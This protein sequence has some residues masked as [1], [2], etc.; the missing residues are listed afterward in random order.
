[1][2]GAGPSDPQAAAR[3]EAA[4]RNLLHDVDRFLRAL[5]TVTQLVDGEDLRRE[6]DRHHSRRHCPCGWQR[7]YCFVLTMRS[8]GQSSTTSWRVGRSTQCP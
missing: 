4:V 8:C 7:S 6:R 1:M 2:P 5:I 3:R